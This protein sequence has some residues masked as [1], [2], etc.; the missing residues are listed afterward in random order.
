VALLDQP[1]LRLATN[2]LPEA[3]ID[4]AGVIAGAAHA[5]LGMLPCCCTRRAR[6]S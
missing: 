5:L 4:R 6:C 2:G 3:V 1:D